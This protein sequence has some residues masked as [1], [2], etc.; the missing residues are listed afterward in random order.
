MLMG[1]LSSATQVVTIAAARK[2]AIWRA[3]TS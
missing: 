2:F 3:L 1:A